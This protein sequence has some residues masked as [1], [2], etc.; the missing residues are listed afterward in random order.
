M[1]PNETSYMTFLSITNSNSVVILNRFGD[2]GQSKPV[3]PGLTFQGHSR[4]RPT[5]RPAITGSSDVRVYRLNGMERTLKD[6]MIY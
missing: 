3:G 6:R 1:A 2:I 4:W 5:T